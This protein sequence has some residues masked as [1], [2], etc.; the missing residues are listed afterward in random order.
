M[1][2]APRGVIREFESS[3]DARV[4]DTVVAIDRVVDGKS[5]SVFLDVPKH[6]YGEPLSERV[7]VSIGE[8]VEVD[9]CLGY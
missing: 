2:Q 4:S 3:G 5:V 8:T 7:K 9:N 6:R 1:L